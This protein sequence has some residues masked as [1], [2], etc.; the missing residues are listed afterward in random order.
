MNNIK[1]L[2]VLKVS[3]SL[4]LLV[5]ATLLQSC[6]RTKPSLEEAGTPP[7][8]MMEVGVP[9]ED[10]T[11]RW[12]MKVLE[13]AQIL[14]DKVV[15]LRIGLQN[16]SHPEP[17]A[18]LIN[19]S[20][21]HILIIG[22]DADE[23]Q[24]LSPRQEKAGEI[25]VST[26]FSHPGEYILA[27]QFTTNS[28]KNHVLV[29]KLSVGKGATGSARNEVDADKAK[30]V[31][32]YEFSVSDLP[33]RAGQMAMPT[34][35]ITRDSRPLSNIQ[36]IKESLPKVAGYAVIISENGDRVIRTAPVSQPSANKL[37]Q[38]PIMFHTIVP[39][40]GRY[41]IWGQFRIN[42]KIETVSFSFDVR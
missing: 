4:I 5:M 31:D 25:L 16:L 8:T 12:Q 11:E 35:R 36:S 42:S 29:Q 41:K 14:P 10:T 20:E 21:S 40:A 15:Q 6:S 3:G 22:K 13:P 1:R 32:G 30:V 2:K 17:E 26:R 38:S 33:E 39:T 24:N 37:F 18:Q 28:N 23:F 34:F 19:G 27:W 9:V 7:M